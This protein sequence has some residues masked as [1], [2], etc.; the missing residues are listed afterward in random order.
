MA[1]PTTLPRLATLDPE[2]LARELEEQL[3][4]H[5]ARLAVPLSPGTVHVQ[6]AAAGESDLAATVR[7]LH[8]WAARGDGDAEEA[9][10][11]AGDL[12]AVLYRPPV[13]GA[14]AAPAELVSDV[15]PTTAAGLLLVAAAARCRIADGGAVAP[16]ELA[17][18]AG[19][20]AA[21]VRLLVRQGEIE[22]RK[23]GAREVEIPAAAARRWLS[24]RGVPGFDTGKRR[25]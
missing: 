4:A 8:A 11:A 15:A 13:G 2:A 19:V 17:A 14:P 20:D 10:E 3:A 24:G 6:R 18:L 12:A 23:A 22:A 9:L 1:P 21:H 7:D 25:R 16:R 5:L